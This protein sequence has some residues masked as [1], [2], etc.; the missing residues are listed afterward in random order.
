MKEFVV[1]EGL[2]TADE[3][4]SEQYHSIEG[5]YSSSQLKD[6]DDPEYFYK[7]YIAKEVEKVHI[8][9]FDVGTYFHTSLLEPEKIQSECA[10][11]TG[12]RRGK[13]WD[14]F[15]ATHAG[16]AII[17]DSE[18]KVALGLVKAVQDSPVSMGRLKRG[19]S[20]VSGFIQ[21]RVVG[22]FVYAI[23]WK[24]RLD[25]F[26]WVDCKIPAKGT[27]VWMKVRADKLADDFILDLKSTTGN[28]KDANLMRKKVA[29][30]N[31]DLSAALYL[32]IFSA[33]REKIVSNFIWTFASK[34]YFNARSYLASQDMILIGRAKWK[35]A[36]VAL[37]EGIENSW[38]FEDSMGILNPPPW[39]YEIIKEQASD[40]L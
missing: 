17:T 2:F 5:T 25:K 27:D 11:F 9:A 20:E 15:Q 32:D 18:H 12:I 28:A 10:V 39:E 7:K 24:K 16:K 4:S 37:A 35:K 33:V 30:L 26:G 8:P 21:L 29:D 13:E 6:C 23:T 31:Y 38:K 14:A 34:D 40:L 22:S 36:V 3:I 19:D 1:R